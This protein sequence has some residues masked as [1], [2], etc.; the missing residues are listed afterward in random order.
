MV[1]NDNPFEASDLESAPKPLSQKQRIARIVGVTFCCIAG[2]Y[3]IGYLIVLGLAAYLILTQSDLAQELTSPPV[4]AGC[5]FG[6]ISAVVGIRAGLAWMK[7]EW[8]VALNRTLF[9]G[10]MLAAAIYVVSGPN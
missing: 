4:V 8:T 5:L 3:G 9:C 10:F 1:S 6:I 7:S 2:L